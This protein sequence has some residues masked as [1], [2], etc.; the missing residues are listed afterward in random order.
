MKM[1]KIPAKIL[2]TVVRID[3]PCWQNFHV[4]FCVN[5]PDKG[6]GARILI[7][8]ECRS[9]RTGMLRKKRP[10]LVPGVLPYVSHIGVI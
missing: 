5:L 9:C 3:H 7:C 1:I 2:L 4:N 10:I 8:D 6:P